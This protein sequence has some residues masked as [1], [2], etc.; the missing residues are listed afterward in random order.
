MTKQEALK[1]FFDRILVGE[2]KSYDD[3]GYYVCTGTTSDCYRSYIKGSSRYNKRFKLMPNDITT[4]TL[5]SIIY[6][7][8]LDKDSPTG[9]LFGVG[10]YAIIPVTLLG[11]IKSLKIPT[12][13]KFTPELQDLLGYGLLIDRKNL[14]NYLYKNVPDTTD[15][16]EQ[17]AMD[18]AMIWSSLG[19]P[20]D[21]TMTYQGKSYS[22]KKNMSYYPFDKAT[23][24]T[25]TVQS[26]LKDLRNDLSSAT[27]NSDGKSGFNSFFLYLLLAAGYYTYQQFKK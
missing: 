18:A 26:A 25:S 21:I 4:Y 3:Y 22:P 17:A 8:G 14:R 24:P 20:K 10:R 7:Q 16:L 23:V 9:K 1:K 13:S 19:I 2:T 12:N 6:W 15:T 11:L 27:T 5:D